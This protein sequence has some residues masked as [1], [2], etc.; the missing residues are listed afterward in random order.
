MNTH[1]QLPVN[2][3]SEEEFDILIERV[4]SLIQKES[5]SP[6]EKIEFRL[7]SNLVENYDAKFYPIDA[8]DPIRWIKQEMNA[9]GWK[10]KDLAK[11]VGDKGLTSHILNNKRQI[12]KANAL[13]IS[14]ALNIPVEVLIK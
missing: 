11:V 12:S 8:V 2:I 9:R 13:K 3:N 7:I 6:Y 4:G 1:T 5:L 14:K 10:S